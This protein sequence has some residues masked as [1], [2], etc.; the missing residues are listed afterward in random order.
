VLS[1]VAISTEELK[2]RPH[3]EAAARK[4]DDVIAMEAAE[5][6]GTTKGASAPWTPETTA[7]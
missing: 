6:G 3:S 2:V 7:V 5:F 1:Q 4:R